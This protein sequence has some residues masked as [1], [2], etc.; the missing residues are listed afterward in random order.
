[1]RFAKVSAILTVAF[2]LIAVQASA[3]KHEKLHHSKCEHHKCH[4]LPKKKHRCKRS[5]NHKKQ[6]CHRRKGRYAPKLP[7]AVVEEDSRVK[8]NPAP[9]PEKLEIKNLQIFWS[10]SKPSMIEKACAD[11][12]GAV[13]DAIAVS[14]E[15]KESVFEKS[16][17]AGDPKENWPELYCADYVQPP[18]C[19][20]DPDPWCE[21]FISD[22]VWAIVFDE[23]TGLTA[24]SE[25]V[26][27]EI[28]E[29]EGEEELE[30]VE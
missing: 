17:Y 5:K 12:Y 2:L 10:Q 3:R 18:M 29:F 27:F 26:T 20:E 9:T 6:R 13:P 23:S 21:A 25:R 4:L 8:T 11:V 28:E 1:M 30:G 22:E 24:E 15:A 7:G 16:Y 19:P 14:F